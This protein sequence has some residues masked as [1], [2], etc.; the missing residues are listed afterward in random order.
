MSFMGLLYSR[1][2]PYFINVT[3]S[4]DLGITD[5]QL[6]A[7]G[8]K[9]QVL[10]DQTTWHQANYVSVRPCCLMVLAGS[11]MKTGGQVYW[12]ACERHG[13]DNCRIETQCLSLGDLEEIAAKLEPACLP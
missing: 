5:D 6:A 9:F 2:D 8:G 3:D 11:S 12:E 7:S 1:Y 13:D 10:P 4:E